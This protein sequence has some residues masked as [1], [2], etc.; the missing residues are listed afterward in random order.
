MHHSSAKWIE[1]IFQN[2]SSTVARNKIFHRRD[3]SID[4]I[5]ASP[6]SYSS[7]TVTSLTLLTRYRGKKKYCNHNFFDSV[8]LPIEIFSSPVGNGTVAKRWHDAV[9]LRLYNT[10]RSARV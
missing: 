2:H 8:W 7:Y 6:I 4:W 3:S 5:L 1:N 9:Y 10:N